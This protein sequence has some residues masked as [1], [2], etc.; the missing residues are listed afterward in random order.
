MKSL[1]PALA[2]ILVAPLVAEILPGSAPLS[3]PGLL[4]F[5]V[6]IYGPGALL[7]RDVLR[8]RGRG[9]IGIL[10]LGAAY[11]FIEEGI[12]LQSLFNPNL[13]NASAWGRLGPVNAVYT[14]AVIPIHAVWSAAV[15]ILLIDLLFPERRSRPYLGRVGL[16]VTGCW[17]AAG[18]FVLGLLTRFSIA[19][20]YRAEPVLLAASAAAALLL[21]IVAL[22]LPRG[23]AQPRYGGKPVSSRAILFAAATAGLIWHVLIAGLWRVDPVFASWPFVLVPTLGA[24]GLLVAAYWFVSQWCAAP[25]WC[26]KH[27]LA[28]AAGAVIAHSIFG[29][30]IFTHSALDRT[31]IVVLGSILFLLVTPRVQHAPRMDSAAPAR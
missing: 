1:R 18:V 23:A 25:G 9:W 11:G 31:G 21:S 27:W 14:E 6:L 24:A 30:V 5:I 26:D 10:L 13:Y 15:P 28:L 19:P 7:I 29:A 3:R 2:L 17:Y 20:G 12:A 8:R 16:I 22:Y 4:P